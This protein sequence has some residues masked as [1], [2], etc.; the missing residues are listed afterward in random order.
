MGYSVTLARSARKELERLADPLALRV[1]HRIEALATE[2]RPNGCRKL[3]G[4]DDLWRLRVGD[5]RI[6]YSIDDHRRLIDVVAIRHRSD[7]YR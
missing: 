6:I 5:Y 2:P 1:L 7:V 3:V 4:A